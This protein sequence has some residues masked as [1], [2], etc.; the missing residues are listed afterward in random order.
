V[1]AKA[2]LYKKK[3]LFVSKSKSHLREKLVKCYI[4]SIALS[5]A[6]TG[7]PWKNISGIP[8]KFLKYDA[9]EGRGRSI[10]LIV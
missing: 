3:T 9:G 6:E 10:S 1:T 5:G 8:G 7:T 2:A 4:W